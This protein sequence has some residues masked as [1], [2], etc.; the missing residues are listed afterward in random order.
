MSTKTDNANLASKLALRRYFLGKYH[1]N[2]PIRVFDCCQGSGIIWSSLRKDFEVSSYWGVDVKKKPGRLKVDSARVLQCQLEQNVVDIDTYG[3]PWK[4]WLNLLPN[5]RESTTVFLTIGLVKIGGGTT[6]HEML[7]LL[8]LPLKT[9]K[10]F[11]ARISE[12]GLSYMFQRSCDFGITITEAVEAVSAGNARY[13]GVR[14]E[15]TG[16]GGGGTPAQALT[17]HEDT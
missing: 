8:G 9:P 11:S 3:S 6:S 15:K 14:L 4:H 1:A 12:I 16:P 13:V 2:S 10:G 7:R 5:V 17:N